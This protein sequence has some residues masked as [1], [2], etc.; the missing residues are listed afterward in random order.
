MTSVSEQFHRMETMYKSVCL[1]FGE[2]HRDTEPGQLFK[3]LHD[4]VS[5]F[6]VCMSVQGIHVS[7]L[8]PFD[9]K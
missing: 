2:S 8:D 5:E 4:F 3:V 1:Q 7:T 9:P 6:K